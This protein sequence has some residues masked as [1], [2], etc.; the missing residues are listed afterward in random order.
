M[1]VAVTGGTGF[2]GKNLLKMLNNK[3]EF[4]ILGRRSI[5][6][7]IIGDEKYKYHCTD[8]S[9][10][11]LV[12]CFKNVDAVVHLS[13]KKVEYDSKFDDYIS[14]NIV[15]TSNV[16]EAC[17]DTGIKNVINL[18]SRMTYDIDAKIPWVEN[19]KENPNTYYGISKL[20]IDKLANYYNANFDMQIKS[21]RASQVFGLNDNVIDK[22]QMG[23][24][25]MKFIDL[26]IKKQALTIYGDGAGVRDYIYIKDLI[27]S[28][29]CA[30][31]SPSAN[32]IFN[33]GSGVGIS[34]KELATKINQ[35]FNNQSNL[36]Y[37]YDV[38][39]D[40]SKHLLD[41]DKARRVLK[42][43]PEYPLEKALQ[44]IKRLLEV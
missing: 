22:N 5:D 34:H 3:Y 32:G 40:K 6:N 9:V 25:I 24:M 41:I 8:Y 44:D 13:S 16:F 38:V 35:I 27:N 43:S 30:L 2:I 4:I 42:Y 20:T 37:D 23:F 33:I 31:E 28:I 12:N 21:L 36:I 18:S 7:Y 19:S 15:L 29:D 10:E 39:E 1:R 11:Q 14:D 26:A 17:R